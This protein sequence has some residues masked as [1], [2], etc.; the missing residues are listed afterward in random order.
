[1]ASK[2]IWKVAAGAAIIALIVGGLATLRDRLPASPAS[3]EIAAA[4]G[5]ETATGQTGN[6]PATLSGETA[7]TADLTAEAADGSTTLSA[8]VA[9]GALTTATELSGESDEAETRAR[10]RYELAQLNAYKFR[11]TDPAK[12]QPAE[13]S[14]ALS[15][16][17]K[18]YA[19]PQELLTALMLVESGGSH[20]EADHSMEGGFGV[21]NLKEN[22]LVNT[23]SEA[24]NLIGRTE[25]EVLYDQKVNVEAGAALLARYYE[26]AVASGLEGGDAWYIAV[27][28]YS[29]RPNPEL[30]AALADEVAG[31]MMR[32]METELH[33]GG[34]T[35]RLPPNPQPVFYPKNWRLAGVTPPPAPT[36]ANRSQTVTP[37]SSVAVPATPDSAAAADPGATT[38]Q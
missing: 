4:N 15:E 29:G 13:L 24:A 9:A 18:K 30:A 23:L 35:V 17:S 26:D 34:G 25:E 22:N 31:M 3:G 7:T 16:A 37:D 19:I 38:Q 14:P 20:R 5:A 21:M 10:E 2:T 28:Q 8:E 6:L 33:D 32:G 11:K 1:M 12:I 27:S 36:D